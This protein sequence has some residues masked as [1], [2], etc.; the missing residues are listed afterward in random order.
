MAVRI[1][2]ARHGTKKKP[3]YRVVVTDQENKRDG[4]FIE[5]VGTYCPRD[6]QKTFSLKQDRI[7]Y[8]LSKGAQPSET[9]GILI[10]KGAA[11]ASA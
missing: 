6:K 8:W 10:K 9:V 4:R 2:L 1:R 7:Q 11:A 5:V 3:F